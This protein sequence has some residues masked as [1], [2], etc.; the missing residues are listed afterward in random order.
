MCFSW[1]QQTLELSVRQ[2]GK[3]F[4]YPSFLFS[5]R[6]LR[7]FP[8]HREIGSAF[9]HYLD[10][11]AVFCFKTLFLDLRWLP[12]WVQTGRA[13]LY[14]HSCSLQQWRSLSSFII[15]NLA[16]MLWL[17]RAHGLMISVFDIQLI[18]FSS[19]P[20][21]CPWIAPYGPV[22]QP[23]G[24]NCQRAQDIV[25]DTVH[26][27]GCDRSETGKCHGGLWLCLFVCVCWESVQKGLV[28][29]QVT[30]KSKNICV[31][32]LLPYFFI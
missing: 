9:I 7:H 26:A 28:L 14:D 19:L 3:C 17:T 20:A 10:L 29:I 8:A 15:S 22:L 12:I 5:G 32:F 25:T 6:N 2:E 1:A 27:T 21:L 11:G 30:G 16:E 18:C 24:E 13:V 31:V 4:L 23:D